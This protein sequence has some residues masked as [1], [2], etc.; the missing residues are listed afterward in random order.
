MATTAR[1]L[2][3]LLAAAACAC[4]S[5]AFDVP[6]VAFEDGFSPLF[7]DGNLVRPADGRTARLLL[8]RRSGNPIDPF[9]YLNETLCYFHCARA[10]LAPPLY[11]S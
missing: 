9:A 10:C 2:A 4:L 5:A 3:A 8:D 6:S 7:G 1:L 11:G